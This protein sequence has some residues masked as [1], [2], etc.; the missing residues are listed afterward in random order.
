MGDLDEAPA[1][2]SF[3]LVLTLQRATEMAS[4]ISSALSAL[5]EYSRAWSCATVRFMPQRVPNSPL[6]LSEIKLA[7]T[8]DEV[9]REMA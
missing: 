9:R 7:H 3:R 8:D 6:C 1:Y 5:R 4:A 2:N